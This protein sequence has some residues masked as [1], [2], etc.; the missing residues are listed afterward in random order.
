MEM[1]KKIFNKSSLLVPLVSILLGLLVGA[2]AMLAGGY[3]PLLAYGSL[4]KRVFGSSYH[5]GE[6]IRAIT[7]LIFTGLAV[8]FAFRTGLFNIGV[9]GQFIMGMTGATLIGVLLDLPWYLHGPLAILTGAL[10][11]GLWAGLVGYLKAKRGVNEVISSIMLNWTALYLANYI[12]TKFLLEPGQQ[13]S[14][15][16]HE[17][18]LMSIDWLVQL[19]DK[20]RMH[21]GTF[22]AL[23]CVLVFYILL[24]RTKQGYELRAVGHNPDAALYAGMNVNRTIVKSMFISGVFAGL[25]GVFEILGVFGNQTVLAASVGYGFDGIAVALLGGNTPI[26]VL[27]GAVLFG[28]LSYG[29]NG[30]SFG[31]GVPSE[32]VRIVIGSVIFFVAAHGIVKFILKPLKL[33]RSD[34]SKEAA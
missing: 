6:T 30:M 21:W 22:V 8:A 31:A 34:K 4:F 11:G 7:P 17:S 23:A 10:F 20:A 28:G 9:E 18:A 26:G 2:L 1:I 19:M 15:N 24:W 27:L 16:V 3:D 32:I 12:V 14:R 33:K 5:M 25:G 13:K 29:S